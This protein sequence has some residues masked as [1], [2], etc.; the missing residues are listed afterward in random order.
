MKRFALMALLVVVAGLALLVL[1]SNRPNYER[2]GQRDCYSERFH[3]A[4]RG[5]VAPADRPAAAIGQVALHP[6]RADATAG[7]RPILAGAAALPI[8]DIV[9]DMQELAIARG[10]TSGCRRRPRPRRM[11]GT[12]AVARRRAARSRRRQ[13]AC[14]AVSGTASR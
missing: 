14:G 3:H 12:R 1:C 10:P 4:A 2:A 9:V 13:S 6:T 5:G 8:D 7:G 11:Q